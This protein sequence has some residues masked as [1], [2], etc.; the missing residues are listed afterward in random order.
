[1]YLGYIFMLLQVHIC[2]KHY[3]THT[4]M[5]I[6]VCVCIVYMCVCVCVCVCMVN[7]GLSKRLVTE[8]LPG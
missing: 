8:E 6:C 7:S 1:M 3:N 5:Y 4:H 2:S